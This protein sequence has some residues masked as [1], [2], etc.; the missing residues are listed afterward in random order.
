MV[1][2]GYCLSFGLLWLFLRWNKKLH[3]RSNHSRCSI[4]ESEVFGITNIKY[5]QF[6]KANVD[7]IPQSL[8]QF[9]GF[10]HFS[11]I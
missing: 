11:Y 4:V 5:N 7:I 10:S 1:I 6:Y 9:L 2:L 8:G 3:L